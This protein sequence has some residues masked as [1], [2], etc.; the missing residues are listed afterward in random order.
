MARLIQRIQEHPYPCPYLP[1]R[2]ASRDIRI[3]LDVTTDELAVLLERG[4]RRFGPS[5]FR[6]ACATCAECISVR[7]PVA[8]FHPSRNQRRARNNAAHLSRRVAAPSVDDERLDLYRR[9]HARREAERGWEPNPLTAEHY[10]FEFAFP[11]PAVREIS[12]R[13]PTIGGRLVGLGIVD[14]VPRALSAAYFFWDPE[15]APPSLGTA[16]IVAL[17]ADA[18]AHGMDHVYLGY[19]VKGCPSLAYKGRFRPLE[20]LDGDADGHSPPLWVPA[21]DDADM[22]DVR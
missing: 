9:W 12:F 3:M 7:I 15:F 11:H 20:V 10:T 14:A 2:T 22:S 19:H 16:H 18:A 6:P 17:V 5:Y 4:W 1:E 21:P 8:H 13:D